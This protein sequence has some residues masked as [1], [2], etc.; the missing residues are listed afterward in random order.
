[1]ESVETASRAGLKTINYTPGTATPADYTT[2]DMKSY[3]CSKELI[4]KLFTFEKEKGLNGAI[5]LIHPGVQDT[6]TDKLYDQL[7]AIIKRLKRLGYTF[8]RLK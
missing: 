6:R 7:G 2:P 4:D 8:E 5:I 1:M 3:K